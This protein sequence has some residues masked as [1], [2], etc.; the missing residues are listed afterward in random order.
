MARTLITAPASAKRG[1]LVEIRV[2][3][4]HPMETGFR[5]GD[6]GR[7]LPRDIITRFVCHYNDEPVFAADLFP[8]ISANPYLAF[9]VRATVSA[10]LR[11]GW[12]GDKGFSQAETHVL[13]ITG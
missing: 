2:L 10:T 7:L 6:E 9:Y 11:F 12:E 13:S 8:A 3:I 5:S 1:D 4:G